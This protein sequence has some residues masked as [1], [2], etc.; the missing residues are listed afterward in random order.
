MFIKSHCGP[1]SLFY[2][3]IEVS[4]YT[5]KIPPFTYCTNERLAKY[6]SARS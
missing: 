5:A 4:G 3:L 1:G 2:L 6:S